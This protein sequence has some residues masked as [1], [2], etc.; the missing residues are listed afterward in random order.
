MN[1]FYINS[2]IGKYIFFLVA[3]IL[4]AVSLWV[5]NNL[6]QK[7]EKEERHKMEI[8]AAATSELA[9]ASL[10]ADIDLIL[11]IIQSNTTI[12][13]IVADE[14]DAIVQYSNIAINSAD[15]TAFLARK[16]AQYKEG[17][18]IIEIDLGGGMKQ[19]LYYEDSILLKQ[20]SYFPYIQL[21]VMIVFALIAYVGLVSVK[22]AEQNKV[23]VGLSKETA[24]QLGTPISSLMAW[25]EL[26]KITDGVDA[27]IVADMDK[28]VK[29]LSTIAERFS[30]IG[31]VPDKELVYINELL[32]ETCD[33]MSSRISSKVKLNLSMPDDAEGVMVCRALVEWVIENLCKNAVDAMG[34]E[35]KI[36]VTLSAG[37]KYVY[38]DVADTGKGIARKEFDNVFKPGYTTKKR[39]WGLGLTLAKRIVEE[40]HDGA[41]YVKESELGVGTTFRIELPRVV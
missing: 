35:G 3:A 10:D 21:L 13:V 34:G 36:D 8:W 31:S 9:S 1:F 19:Y 17:D 38:I 29:R 33:Y 6:V 18:S 32:S 39:G 41:I 26:L 14:D 4:V 16:L 37:R 15:T 20:L 23:W 11:T 28:D 12:P 7:L 25:I 27:G 22:R 30:K 5:S 40:Y 24:H 2:R